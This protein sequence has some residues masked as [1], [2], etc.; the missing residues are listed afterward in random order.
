[1]TL[2]DPGRDGLG[3]P[4]AWRDGHDRLARPD[5]LTSLQG[6]ARLVGPA[7]AL[8]AWQDAATATGHHGTDLAPD[9]LLELAEVLATRDGLLRVFGV[10]LA[11]R[12]RTR[13]VLDRLPAGARS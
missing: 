3:P 12:V 10:S 1:M 2:L 11:A 4:V 13:L 6:L 8:Q 9:Q 5:V 7:E